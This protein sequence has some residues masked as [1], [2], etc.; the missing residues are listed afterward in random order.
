MWKVVERSDGKRDLQPYSRGL[1]KLVEKSVFWQSGILRMFC[2]MSW[3]DT[4]HPPL[5]P[6]YFISEGVS[7]GSME[8]RSGFSALWLVG[9]DESA[10]L[11]PSSVFQPHHSFPTQA[12]EGVQDRPPKICFFD[13]S[14]ILKTAD[15]ERGFWLLPFNLK[16]GH[17]ISHERGA[18]PV[19]GRKNAL[20]TRHQ[21][22]LF[23]PDNGAPLIHFA[24]ESWE[25]LF[26]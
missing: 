3:S 25:G 19:P 9:G 20:I 17:I 22:L 18:L 4:K 11:G 1:W 16:T 23:Y 8:L 13:I 7:D 14:V 5:L 6:H 24:T 21:E 2:R 10:L 26:K 15:A 12:T